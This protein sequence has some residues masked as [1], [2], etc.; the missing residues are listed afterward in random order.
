MAQDAVEYLAGWVAR[1]YRILF[2]ELGSTTTEINKNQ[3]IHGHD[4]GIPSWISHLSYGDLRI[5]SNDFLKYI[6]RIEWL[7]KKITKQEI[8]KGSGVIRRLTNKIFK[9]MEMPLKYLPVVRTYIKQRLLIRMKYSYQ[10]A[11]KLCN[12]RKAKAQ[13]QKLQ[14][15]KRLMT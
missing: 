15:L 14:K 11:I 8:P 3:S 9:R 5:P 2:P 7:F 4:Y 13:L 1:K 10:H 6:T 12:K